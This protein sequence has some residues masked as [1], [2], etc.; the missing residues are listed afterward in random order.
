MY[1]IEN[2][3]ERLVE[4]KITFYTACG[5]EEL[6]QPKPTSPSTRREWIIILKGTL[7]RI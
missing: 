5:L 1:A 6:Y 2:A 7:Q 3:S 4:I